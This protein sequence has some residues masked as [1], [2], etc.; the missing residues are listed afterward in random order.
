MNN[1]ERQFHIQTVVSSLQLLVLV[2]GVA[3][4][5]TSIGKRD[6]VITHTSDNLSEIKG[7]VQELVKS[8][9]EG[10]TKDNEHDRV[11][12]DLRIRVYRLEQP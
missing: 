6:Q 10:A 5:F 9:V 11:L 2:I 12:E 4:V 1:P 7:I 8:Q 3:T